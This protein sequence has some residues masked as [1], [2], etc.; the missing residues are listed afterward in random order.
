MQALASIIPNSWNAEQRTLDVEFASGKPVLRYSWSNDEIYQEVLEITDKAINFG[1]INQG[2]SVLKDHRHYN[3]DAVVGITLTGWTADGKARASIKLSGTS[4]HESFR[5]NV[6]EG[7]YRNISVGYNVDEY[8]RSQT[9]K[10]S[11]PVYRATSWEPL[12]IS[13]VGIP[14][15]ET[16]GTRSLEEVKET[17]RKFRSEEVNLHLT[18]IIDTRTMDENAEGAEGTNPVNQNQQRGA[19]PDPTPTPVDEKKLTEAARKAEKARSQGIRDAV[20]AAKLDDAFAQKMIDNDVTIDEARAKIIDKWAANDP[21]KGL[22]NDNT[23]EMG[24]DEVDKKRAVR[25]AALGMRTGHIKPKNIDKELVVEANKLRSLGLL[26]MARLSLED[27]GLRTAGLGKEEIAKR[28]ITQSTSDFPVLLGSVGQDILLAS[29]VEINDVWRRFC[30]TGS[31]SDFRDHRA[32]R[33]WGLQ[34]LPRVLETEEYK[35]IPLVDAT[36]ESVRVFKHGG[37]VNLSLEMIVNDDLGAFNNVIAD[38]TRSSQRTIEKTVFATIAMNGNRG[39][40]MADGKT[41]FHADHNNI[42]T[43]SALDGTAYDG[44]R[45]AMQLQKDG[46]GELIA[47]NPSILLVH[48]VNEAKAKMYNTSTYDLDQTGKT[49]FM[50]NKALGIYEDIVGSPRF[51]LTNGAISFADPDVEPVLQVSFL[52]GQQTPDFE[53]YEE[54]RTDGVNFKI[55]SI[56]GVG[57]VG[58]RGAMLNPGL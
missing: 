51:A 19:A 54:F 3:L 25:A 26:D 56:F 53:R 10:T 15:D 11:V 28:A 29:Y 46:A 40:I 45:V 5:Q 37:I 9:D 57:A 48:T 31:V 32:I 24:T 16:V 39:P 17:E 58:W 18:T 4:E 50:P 52:D 43:G 13:F 8:V 44:M 49:M 42:L 41:L 7:I 27:T 21:S 23:I 33:T 35:N 38:L 30:R 2:A 14:A 55:R 47:L 36:G 6:A 1:R 12:E 22:R 34:D 20:R